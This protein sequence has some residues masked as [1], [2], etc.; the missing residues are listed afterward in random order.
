MFQ[1]TKYRRSLIQVLLFKQDLH[2]HL[3][4]VF[5]PDLPIQGE[6]LALLRSELRDFRTFDA[7]K[8]GCQNMTEPSATLP[9]EF[10]TMPDHAQRL[11]AYIVNVI[12]RDHE[13]NKIFQQPAGKKRNIKEW[14]DSSPDLRMIAA[15]AKNAGLAGS[16]P[17]ASA[18][19]CPALGMSLPSICSIAFPQL[20]DEGYNEETTEV[21]DTVKLRVEEVKQMMTRRIRILDSKV[22][23]A[24]S[25]C[26]DSQMFSVRDRMRVG[27]LL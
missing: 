11:A 20:N 2:Q 21:Y 8:I 6:H 17:Q 15:E 14:V 22:D 4:S 25:G 19:S 10:Q 16:G 3:L 13:D 9:P 26:P 24:T 7:L 18:S 27:A 23:D 12:F 1:G 5:A